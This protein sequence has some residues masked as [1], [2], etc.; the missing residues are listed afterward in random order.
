MKQAPKQ[1]KRRLRAVEIGEKF[2][3]L[4]VVSGEYY[5]YSNH[6]A[7][8]TQCECGTI[9]RSTLS[10]LLNGKAISCGCHLREID[11]EPNYKHG[12]YRTYAYNFWR[13]MLQRCGNPK[14]KSYSVFK[15]KGIRVASEWKDDFKSFIRDIGERPSPNHWLD[16]VNRDGSFEPGNCKWISK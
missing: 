14:N 12:K 1:R 11:C 16:R 9:I 13:A 6:R 4:T 2:N 8:N 10:R 7:V 15:A 3:R 5:F